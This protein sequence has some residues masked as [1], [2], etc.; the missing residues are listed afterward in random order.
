MILMT[1]GAYQSI[2]T[3]VAMAFTVPTWSNLLCAE[4]IISLVH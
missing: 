2:I 4:A 3:D 1:T